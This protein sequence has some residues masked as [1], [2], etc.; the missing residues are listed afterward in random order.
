MHDNGRRALDLVAVLND[1]PSGRLGA[2]SDVLH[3]DGI[4]GFGHNW[5]KRG[6]GVPSMVV[7]SGWNIDCLPVSGLLH[8][9]CSSGKLLCGTALSSFEVYAI[10]EDASVADPAGGEQTP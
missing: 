7:P 3:L 6:E 4:G 2:G 5:I 1:T 8:L 9:Y 10:A